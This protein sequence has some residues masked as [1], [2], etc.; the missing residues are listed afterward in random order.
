MGKAACAAVGST[1]FLSTLLNLSMI[2]S[3]TASTAKFNNDYKALVCIQLLGGND[4]FNMIVPNDNTGYNDY[5]AIRSSLALPKEDLLPLNGVN[6]GLH[7][8]MGDVQNLY[9]N[10]NAAFLCNVGTLVEPL[11]D[12]SAYNSFPEKRPL[13]LRSHSDQR[14]QWQTSVP[15]SR[16]AL[17]WGGRLADIMTNL[18]TSQNVS[19]NISLGGRNVFQTGVNVTDYSTTRRG[20]E[21]IYEAWGINPAISGFVDVL[22][23]NAAKD[24]MTSS[25]QNIFQQS[26]ANQMNSSISTSEIL[27]KAVS[28]VP[29]F[30]TVFSSTSLSEDL[31]MVA[32]IIAAQAAM[33]MN[34]QTFFVNV[35]GWDMHSNLL[36]YHDSKLTELNNALAE[37]NSALAEIN[38]QNEVT[39]FTISDF[40][41]TLTSNNDGS[42]HAWGGHQIV[43]GGAVNGGQMYG[44]YPSLSLTNNPLSIDSRGR[45][46]PQISTDEYFAELALWFGVN[47]GELVDVLPNIGNF[48]APLGGTPPLGFM[49][50]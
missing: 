14:Y 45:F 25:Y 46:I 38:R 1:T 49:N 18:N 17:G 2:N 39:T 32:K 7:P 42:D 31:R 23:N 6:F 37:F 43:M 44:T 15:Q 9:N 47:P 41:R 4:S 20:V 11:V 50:M 5:S 35:G 21:Q 12:S 29:E 27:G 40:G 28:N 13:A 19:M 24:L 3:V 36:T 26:F 34:R 16:D 30:T 48:Y 22:K 33:G 8:A 10:N